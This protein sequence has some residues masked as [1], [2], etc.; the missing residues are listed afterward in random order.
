MPGQWEYQIGP[1]GPLELGDE[2]MISRWLLHRLGECGTGCGAVS[3]AD[4]EVA[5]RVLRVLMGQK[6]CVTRATLCVCAESAN[7]KVKPA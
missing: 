5:L 3:S 6:T 1:V 4:T 7:A 2:V